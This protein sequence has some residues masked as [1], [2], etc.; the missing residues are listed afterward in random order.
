MIGEDSLNISSPSFGERKVLMI[1]HSTE[2]ITYGSAIPFP[3]TSVPT[4]KLED[5]SFPG[6]WWLWFNG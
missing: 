3:I 5:H 1:L 2:Y 6:S 4:S